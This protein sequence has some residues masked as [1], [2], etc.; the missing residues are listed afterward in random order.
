VAEDTEEEEAEQEIAQEEDMKTLHGVLGPTVE[1]ESRQYVEKFLK[2]ER[3]N[4]EQALENV[5]QLS[6][7]RIT[8]IEM[9]GQLRREQL[10]TVLEGLEG[11]RK[12]FDDLQ[13]TVKESQGV[14]TQAIPRRATQASLPA[15]DGG[16]TQ[17]HTPHRKRRTIQAASTSSAAESPQSTSYEERLARA[18]HAR[19][20][21]SPTTVDDARG[22]SKPR[23]VAA[24][25]HDR[26][27]AAKA[28]AGISG[29]DGEIHE[30]EPEPEP[31]S[32]LRPSQTPPRPREAQT[33]WL[34][35]EMA[36]MAGQPCGDSVR[37]PPKPSLRSAGRR[38]A[39][40]MPASAAEV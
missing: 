29:D 6:L 24:T 18:V 8:Q 35:K 33:R 17:G 12:R 19:S 5:A 4:E 27:L 36:A 31:A 37:S 20:E 7:K 1:R 10:H 25:R 28:Y 26:L 2:T 32:V 39:G 16:P 23:A 21:A 15:H 40:P 13:N 3:Q 14:A 9:D 34:D 22:T 11:L 30:D 38:W